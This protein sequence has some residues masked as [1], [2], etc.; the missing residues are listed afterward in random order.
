M[1]D[2]VHCPDCNV[3]MEDHMLMIHQIGSMYPALK[4]PKCNRV[5][6]STKT[7]MMIGKDCNKEHE[8]DWAEHD[9]IMRKYIKIDM[10]LD[11]DNNECRK[12]IPKNDPC[13]RGYWIFNQLISYYVRNTTKFLARSDTICPRCGKGTGFSVESEHKTGKVMQCNECEWKWF[14]EYPDKE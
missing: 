10:G 11:P 12:Q 6:I 9:R 3:L 8:P 7:S 4:C 13:G 2:A 14:Y 5:M 1:S